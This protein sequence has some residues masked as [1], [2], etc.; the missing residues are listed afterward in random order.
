[1]PSEVRELQH[2]SRAVRTPSASQNHGLMQ[3]LLRKGAEPVLMEVKPEPA[4]FFTG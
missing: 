4:I 2:F 3:V 1:M